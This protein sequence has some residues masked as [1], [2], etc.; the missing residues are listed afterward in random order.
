VFSLGLRRYFNG[1]KVEETAQ[2]LASAVLSYWPFDEVELTGSAKMVEAV[3]KAL[4]DRI[5]VLKENGLKVAE[6]KTMKIRVLM[7]GR[8]MDWQS[9]LMRDYHYM[10]LVY[11]L[12]R[13][14]NNLLTLDKE[15]ISLAPMASELFEEIKYLGIE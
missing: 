15:V 11:D 10:P 3:E 13:V 2:R 5:K 12:Y 8:A 6:E 9:P 1:S 14:K 4:E 7:V